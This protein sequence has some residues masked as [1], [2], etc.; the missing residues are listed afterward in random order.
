MKEKLPSPLE[1]TPT[2]RGKSSTAITVTTDQARQIALMARRS[3]LKP[4]RL[5]EAVAAM[6]A[7]LSCAGFELGDVRK[8]LRQHAGSFRRSHQQQSAAEIEAEEIA[9]FVGRQT[10]QGPLA[11]KAALAFVRKLDPRLRHLVERR[12]PPALEHSMQRGR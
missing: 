8:L 10:K 11:T 2:G 9:A 6:T 4:T 12:L 3:R 5:L 7:E 1:F